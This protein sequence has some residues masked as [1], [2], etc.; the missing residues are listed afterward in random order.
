MPVFLSTCS[1]FARPTAAISHGPPMLGSGQS[2]QQNSRFP[3]ACVASR[4]KQISSID[5]QNKRRIQI[6]REWK[7]PNVAEKHLWAD[8]IHRADSGVY[9]A[10]KSIA[11]RARVINV[12]VSHSFAFCSSLVRAS[13]AA[14][15]SNSRLHCNFKGDGVM[16]TRRVPRRRPKT[17]P[18]ILLEFEVV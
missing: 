15:P 4:N 12:Q 8:L 3:R 13:R 1:Y 11:I 5:G 7:G 6:A 16:Y 18:N 2:I 14:H 10:R 17:G 9:Q